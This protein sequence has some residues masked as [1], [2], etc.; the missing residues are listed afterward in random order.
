MYVCVKHFG[1]KS[2]TIRTS[3]LLCYV[4]VLSNLLNTAYDSVYYTKF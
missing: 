2:N 3:Y 4:Y 1:V